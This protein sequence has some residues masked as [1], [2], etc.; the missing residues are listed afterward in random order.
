[1]VLIFCSLC[2]EGCCDFIF[3]E[4]QMD[5]QKDIGMD[6]QIVVLGQQTLI[7]ELHS[8]KTELQVSK[9]NLS[10]FSIVCSSM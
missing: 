9:C 7:A 4:A 1:M 3:Q 6:N 2:C 5:E 10:N 8:K